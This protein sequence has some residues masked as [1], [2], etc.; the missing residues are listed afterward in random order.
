MHWSDASIN[1]NEDRREHHF[2]FPCIH[3]V[4][5]SPS[6]CEFCR[7]FFFSSFFL[8]IVHSQCRNAV[9]CLFP[10][11]NPTRQKRKE[12]QKKERIPLFSSVFH[13]PFKFTVY[14]ILLLVHFVF[15]ASASL[16]F[17]FSFFPLLLPFV[18]N[19][20]LWKDK[21]EWFSQKENSVSFVIFFSPCIISP[22]NNFFLHLSVLSFHFFSCKNNWRIL[23]DLLFHGFFFFIIIIFNPSI[24]PLITILW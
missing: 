23:T 21:E 6:S 7:H 16:H 15:Y 20:S 2:F 3:S 1:R 22:T 11:I 17:W 9:L 10:P 12:K 24:H 5:F 8:S 14:T 13:L 18:S 19:L 4:L